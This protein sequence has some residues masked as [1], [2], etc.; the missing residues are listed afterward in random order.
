[1]SKNLKSLLFWI[2]LLFTVILN[3]SIMMSTPE[4]SSALEQLAVIV[5]S[6]LLGFITAFGFCA[7]F[8][9]AFKRWWRE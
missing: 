4:N 8:L 9:Q 6:A 5:F 3:A 2:G 1:M 7:E